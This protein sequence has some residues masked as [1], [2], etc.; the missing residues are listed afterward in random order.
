MTCFSQNTAVIFTAEFFHHEIF[1]RLFIA[2]GE[3]VNVC[4]EVSFG[5]MCRN[6]CSQGRLCS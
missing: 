2:T 3:I 4:D 5:F 6:E 1:R